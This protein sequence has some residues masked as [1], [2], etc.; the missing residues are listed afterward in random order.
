MK[1]EI[2]RQALALADTPFYLFNTDTAQEKIRRLK[3]SLGTNVDICYAM[4]ANPALAGALSG[5]AD[6]L[7]VCSPG[8]FRICVRAGV[9][10]EKIVLSG[11]FKDGADIEEITADY[12]ALG[13][14][15]VESPAQWELLERCSRTAAR[16]LRLLLRLTDGS[17][18]GLEPGEVR[19]II[20]E[21]RDI[22]SVEIAG[23]QFFSGTQKKNTGRMA[24]EL[25]ELDEFIQ[26]LGRDYGFSP[27][28]FEYGPGFPVDYFGHDPDIE[29]TVMRDLSAALASMRYRGRVV[30]EMGREIAACCGSYVTKVVDVKRRGDKN[31]CVVD[32]GIHHINY[33][34]QMMAMETPPVIQWEESGEPPVPWTVFGALCSRN[35]VLLREH[36][37]SGLRPGSRLVFEKA[38][39]YAPTEGAALFLSRDLPELWTYS[40]S[41]GFRLLRGRLRTDVLNYPD[42]Q[43]ES[44]I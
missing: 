22:G 40:A 35:D 38:G 9:P 2:I 19:R 43:S 18:F 30:L 44:E 1:N 6:Y 26:E 37:F 29:D 33:Y 31:L 24:G 39:A 4:K 12:P 23:I 3:N 21:A 5:T 8:E 16:P 7:E 34:G 15:T 41:D 11:V 13:T 14:Y 10:L 28:R 20:E 42:K 27:E 32:G 17:Q 36:P 25:R